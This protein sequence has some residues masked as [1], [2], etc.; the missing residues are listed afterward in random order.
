[1]GAWGLNWTP[2]VR[3]IVDS[4][5]DFERVTFIAKNKMGSFPSGEGVRGCGS[6]MPSSMSPT[7]VTVLPQAVPENT[8]VLPSSLKAIVRRTVFVISFDLVVK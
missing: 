3:I 1:M 7:K 6:A 5:S 8:H 4:M 2:V